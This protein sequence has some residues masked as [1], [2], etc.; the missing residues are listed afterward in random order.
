VPK[1]AQHIVETI[2][3]VLVTQKMVDGN[4]IIVTEKH[5]RIL[6]LR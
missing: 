5:V 1:S 4:F 3:K 6:R 2:S